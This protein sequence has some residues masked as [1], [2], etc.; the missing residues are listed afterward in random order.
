MRHTVAILLALALLGAASGTSRAARE[1]SLIDEFGDWSAFV[2]SD[3]GNKVCWT[4]SE[5]QKEEGRYTR[6]DDTYIQVTHRP[7]EGSLGVISITAGYT[8][9]KDS[10]VEVTIDSHR[11]GLFTDGDRAWAEDSETDLALVRAMSRGMTMIV[12]GTSTRDTLTTDTYSLIGFTAAY[13]AIN[14][15]CGVE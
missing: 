14:R 3:G 15:A 13:R 12:N 2:D 11:F 1:A 6:R 9:R 8:Y 5:P 4:A 7:G 10:K